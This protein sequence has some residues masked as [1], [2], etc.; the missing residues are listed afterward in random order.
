VGGVL[1]RENDRTGPKASSLCA[2]TKQEDVLRDGNAGRGA[3]NR[4]HKW[5]ERL[6]QVQKK[7]KAHKAKE[8]RLKAICEEA[9]RRQALELNPDGE[10]QYL[11]DSHSLPF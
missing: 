11:I 8:A 3:G 6:K 10:A 1:H 5:T 9:R 4:P 7:I 2:H